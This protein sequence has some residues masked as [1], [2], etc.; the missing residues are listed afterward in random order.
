MYGQTSC[1]PVFKC[2]VAAP[3]TMGLDGV[4]GEA[5]TSAVHNTPSHPGGLDTLLRVCHEMSTPPD[6]GAQMAG[7]Y[8]QLSARLPVGCSRA[9]P[10]AR[11]DEDR[12]GPTSGDAAILRERTR[13]PRWHELRAGAPGHAPSNDGRTAAAEDGDEPPCARPL[14][15]PFAP[16]H[17]CAVVDARPRTVAWDV[18][19]FRIAYSDLKHVE[20]LDHLKPRSVATSTAVSPGRGASRRSAATSTTARYAGAKSRSTSWAD[21]LSWPNPLDATG[22]VHKRGPAQSAMDAAARRWPSLCHGAH[23]LEAARAL[24]PVAEN[25]LASSR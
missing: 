7:K 19:C 18:A 4:C 14:G 9:A 1:S 5:Q 13:R 12:R 8:T 11:L 25:V 10:R 20:G 3:R 22:H 2:P 15:D 6:A 23:M 24:C 16:R 21:M 17:A